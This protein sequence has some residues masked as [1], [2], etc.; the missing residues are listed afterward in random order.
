M[1]VSMVVGG[2]AVA[3]ING[4]ELALICTAFLPFLGISGAIFTNL[5][6][7]SDIKI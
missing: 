5:I 3:F 7:T 4:W 1:T 6:Q 2:F